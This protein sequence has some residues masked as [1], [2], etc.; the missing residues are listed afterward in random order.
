MRFEVLA[1]F[2]VGALL[3]ILETARRGLAYWTVN[4]STM[5]EDYVAGGLLLAGAFAATRSKAYALPLLLAGWGYVT[6]MMGSSLWY[7]VEDTVRGVTREPRNAVVLGFKAALWATCVI[8]LVSC[9]RRATPK[10]GQ[11]EPS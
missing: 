7:Q 10:P 2:A 6:G 8:S 5:L 4:V 9:V 1:A 3:P 11:R